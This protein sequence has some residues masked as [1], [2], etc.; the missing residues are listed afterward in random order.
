MNLKSLM[1]CNQ[2]FIHHRHEEKVLLDLK[3]IF[4]ASTND[5]QI[6]KLL[7]KGMRRKVHILENYV[8]KCE[9]DDFWS[10]FKNIFILGMLFLFLLYN[11][12]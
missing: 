9:K 11:K 7:V 1:G 6:L 10:L 2:L 5:L 12:L 3:E 8:E 4:D